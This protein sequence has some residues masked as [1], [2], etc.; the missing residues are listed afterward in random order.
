MCKLLFRSFFPRLVSCYAVINRR[1]LL[2]HGVGNIHII[3]LIVPGT[4]PEMDAERI[5]IV[6]VFNGPAAEIAVE[7][8]K[9][10][11]VFFRDTLYA[12]PGG[13]PVGVIVDIFLAS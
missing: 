12:F 7:C 2:A 11:P 6:V 9:I 10:A 4:V 5:F 3:G 13:D 8:L 1:K